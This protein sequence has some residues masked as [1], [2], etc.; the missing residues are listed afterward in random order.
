VESLGLAYIWQ[1]KT[2]TNTNKVC[3]IIKERHCN[4]VRENVF[5]NGGTDF[6]GI[7]LL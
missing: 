4:I 3:K 6:F 5:S 1:Y 2:E 7:L